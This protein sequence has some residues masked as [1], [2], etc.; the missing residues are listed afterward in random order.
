M[1]D[2]HW[3]TVWLYDT[4]RQAQHGEAWKGHH[5]GS[6][7]YYTHLHAYMC[8]YNSHWKM[9]NKN[10]LEARTKAHRLTAMYKLTNNLIS[11]DKQEYFQATHTH[12][13]QNSHSNK[14]LTCHTNT[15]FY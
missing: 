10:L 13:T 2:Y 1:Y 7:V 12:N 6:Q 8:Y 14:F 4:L 9:I 11:I 3:S 15:E 5:K